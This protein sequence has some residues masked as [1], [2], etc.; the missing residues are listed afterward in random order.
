M[1]GQEGLSY[2]AALGELEQLVQDMESGQLPLEALLQSYRRG[3][4]LLSGCRQRLQVIEQ[5]VKVLEDG[6]LRPW[7]GA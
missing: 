5:Q 4:Q 3:A 1:L 7:D 6:Q 2:E